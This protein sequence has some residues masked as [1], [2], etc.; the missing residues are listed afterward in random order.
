MLLEGVP[1][2]L[3]GIVTF[4]YLDYGIDSAGR[5]TQKE[6]DFLRKEI[7]LD[8]QGKSRHSLKKGLFDLRAWA[9]SLVYFCFV[10]GWN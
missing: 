9:L 2:V 1:V 6:K 7:E 4:F 5:L 8:R 3:L 10:V